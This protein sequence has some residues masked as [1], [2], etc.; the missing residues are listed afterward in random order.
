LKPIPKKSAET[1]FTR[2]DTISGRLAVSAMK[3][4]AITNASVAAGVKPS[5]ASM[6]ITMG[7]RISAAPSLAKS[8]ETAAPSSTMKAKSNAPAPA[9]PTRDVQ[10]GPFEEAGLVEQQAD[11][12]DGDEGRGRVP[13]DAPDDR[14]IGQLHHAEK[15]ARAPRRAMRSSRCPT[16]AAARSPARA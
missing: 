8:A 10:R 7:V 3:P 14:D 5:A 4:A 2:F 15:Q 11:E 12:D 13:H 6:A 9:A 1:M 16:R